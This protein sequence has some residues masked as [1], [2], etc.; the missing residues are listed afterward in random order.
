M[1]QP[2][3]KTHRPPARVVDRGDDGP[4][5]VQDAPPVVEDA[6][7]SVDPQQRIRTHVVRGVVVLDVAGHLHDVAQDLDRAIQMALAEGPRGVVCNLSATL[8]DSQPDAVEMLAMAG[9]HV[10]DWPATPVAVASPDPRVRETL[11]AH[12][13]GGHL[14]VA[15]AMLTALSAVLSTRTPVVEWLRLAPHPT[16][17]RAS[18]D[19][20]SRTLLDWGLGRV[21]PSASLVVSELVTNSTM[22][23]GTD[24]SVS[25]V[26]NKGALRLTVRD[27][28]PRLPHLRHSALDLHGRGLTIVAGLSRAF[29]VLPTSDGGKV[30]WAVLDAPRPGRSTTPSRSVL[31]TKESPMFTIDANVP[32]PVRRP[33]LPVPFDGPKAFAEHGAAG[34]SAVGTRPRPARP[35]TLARAGKGQH[36][37]TH[38]YNDPSNYLG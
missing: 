6:T 3:R 38:P 4:P 7:S 9:R 1:A 21:I 34:H 20:V 33:V 5:V 31:A 18:R 8:E 15:A 25:V 11:S 35:L 37:Y 29:G 13:L 28:S 14:I 27:N 23:A 17:P 19:F 24:I 10:R 22:Y 26:W 36:V 16:A 12:P 32:R 2:S 30:V